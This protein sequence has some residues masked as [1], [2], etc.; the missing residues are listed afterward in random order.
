LVGWAGSRCQKRQFR[1]RATYRKELSR[2]DAD[3]QLTHPFTPL[4]RPVSHSNYED[5]ILVVR[6]GLPKYK[7]FTGSELVDDEGRSIPED[8]AEQVANLADNIDKIKVVD[9]EGRL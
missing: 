8:K 1:V 9:D 5:K 3:R 7:G 2:E 4:C 6:D